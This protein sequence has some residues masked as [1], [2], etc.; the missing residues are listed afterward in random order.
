[1]NKS[2]SIKNIAGALA[3]FHEEMGVVYKSETNPFFKSKY[4]DLA[5][6][7]SAIKEPLQKAGLSSSQF[8]TGEN[9]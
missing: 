6:I 9:E 3:N 2:D 5:T 7:L 4:A 8:P 1:M